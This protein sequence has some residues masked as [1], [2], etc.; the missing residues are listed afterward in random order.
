MV[1]TGEEQLK[2]NDLCSSSGRY[3]LHNVEQLIVLERRGQG[4]FASDTA[5]GTCMRERARYMAP[6]PDRMDQ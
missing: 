5:K 3:P 1:I 6:H 2:I 4:H